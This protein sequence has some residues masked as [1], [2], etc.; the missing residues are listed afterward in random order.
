MLEFV[1]DYVLVFMLVFA[2]LGATIFFNPILGRTNVSSQFKMAFVVILSLIVVPTLDTSYL[3]FESDFSMYLAFSNELM[4]GFALNLVFFLFYYMIFYAGDMLDFTIGLSMA[5]VFDPA[6]NIQM[7]VTGNLFIILFSI[8]FFS[9]NCHLLLIQIITASFTLIQLGGVV[10]PENFTYFM[11]EAFSLSL[12]IILRLIAP[13]IVLQ[14]TIEI[15]LGVLMKLIPQIHVFVLNMQLKIII[16]LTML[17]VL[18]NNILEIL[19]EYMQRMFWAFQ[20]LMTL[21]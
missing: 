7:S 20:E 18:S 4:L 10:I 17:I 16:A 12:S 9:M 13:F 14:F 15:S 6:S 8:Y 21:F 3:I 1:Y 5:K 19:D 11:I 2:R